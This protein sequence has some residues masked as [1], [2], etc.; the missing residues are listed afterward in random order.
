MHQLPINRFIGLSRHSARGGGAPAVQLV[1]ASPLQEGGDLALP[2][3]GPGVQPAPHSRNEV[4]GVTGVEMPR[5]RSP[6]SPPPCPASASPLPCP[7]A[8]LSSLAQPL[9]ERHTLPAPTVPPSLSPPTPGQRPPAHPPRL[10]DL[11]PHWSCLLK[12]LFIPWPFA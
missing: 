12:A 5:R 8:T 10:M 4:G 1:P 2:S 6:R 3:Q 11:R 7:R 9:S